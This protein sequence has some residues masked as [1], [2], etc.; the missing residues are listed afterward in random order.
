[1]NDLGGRGTMSEPISAGLAASGASEPSTGRG[2]PFASPGY[3]ILEML[4]GGK[5][6]VVYKARNTVLGRIVALKLLRFGGGT[7]PQVVARLHS[8]AQMLARLSTSPQVV[9][10]Y[11]V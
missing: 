3:E 9:Q 4:G 7:E 2:P 10:L 8:S 1:M 11:E 5:W 6:S